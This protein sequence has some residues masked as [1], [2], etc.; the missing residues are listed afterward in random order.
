M[1][2]KLPLTST[3]EPTSKGKNPL[4]YLNDETLRMIFKILME[5]NPTKP[6]EIR[7]VSTAFNRLVLNSTSLIKIN[8]EN[9]EKAIIKFPKALFQVT[10]SNID[11]LNKLN[12][13]KTLNKPLEL[14]TSRN[15]LDNATCSLLISKSTVKCL[16]FNKTLHDQTKFKFTGNKETPVECNPTTGVVT[17]CLS[18]TKTLPD[19][20]KFEFT[21]DKE[22]PV[23]CNPTTGVV[24]KC[25]SYT[26]TLADGTKVEY[27]GDKKD[28]I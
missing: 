5:L 13:I 20:T 25:L 2:L 23:E 1:D 27:T 19:E 16:S 24:T 26:E 12:Q 3:T 9:L 6:L 14:F 18:Y 11:H 17:K 22:T 10:V 4:Y 28:P 7:K 21:G 15:F 8:P